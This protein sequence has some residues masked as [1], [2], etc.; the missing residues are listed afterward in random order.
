MLPPQTPPPPRPPPRGR[1]WHEG[2]FFLHPHLSVDVLNR[3]N[4]SVLAPDDRTRGTKWPPS[5]TLSVFGSFWPMQLFPRPM[6]VLFKEQIHLWRSEQPW[7]TPVCLEL[8]VFKK[9]LPEVMHS[10]D[11]RL[12]LATALVPMSISG[13]VKCGRVHCC[14]R[15]RLTN[16][17]VVWCWWFCVL[18]VRNIMKIVLLR[19]FSGSSTS[20]NQKVRGSIPVFPIRYLSVLGQDTTFVRCTI[21]IPAVYWDTPSMH[22]CH[23]DSDSVVRLLCKSL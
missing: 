7:L 8:L 11:S 4:L 14:H 1:D 6:L 13:R 21:K 5:K 22:L 19:R 9:T 3:V 23:L 20:T 2:F 18:R 15:E 16:R 10:T 12:K 17:N